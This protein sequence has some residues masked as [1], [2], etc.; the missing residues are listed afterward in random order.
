MGIVSRIAPAL[1]TATILAATPA[2]GSDLLDKHMAPFDRTD[3][4][5]CAVAL[6]HKGT[7]VEA[8]AYGLA[9]LDHDIPLQTNSVFR[10][11]SVSKQFTAMS[12]RLLIEDGTLAFDDDIRKHIPELPAYAHTVTVRHLMEHSSGLPYYDDIG[13]PY[14]VLPDY[15]KAVEGK[16]TAYYT[17]V[18]MSD[19]LFMERVL[20]VS[21]LHF[22][23]GTDTAY[24]NVGFF[25]LGKI[26]E[27]VSGKHLRDF[28]QER[29]FTP[30]GMTKTFFN[31]QT[32]APVKGRASPYFRMKN[33]RFI[34]W[35]TDLNWIGD[36]G[37]FTTV[38]DLAKWDGNFYSNQLGGGAA[39]IKSMVTSNMSRPDLEVGG[40]GAALGLFVEDTDF[41]KVVEHG[42][43]WVGFRTH[44][45]RHLPSGYGIYML[46]NTHEASGKLPAIPRA[47]LGDAIASAAAA[48]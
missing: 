6:T 31:T 45:E 27:R 42:G 1:L 21:K 34:E 14:E 26:V 4:P 8:K 39:L 46:C 48:K 43:E 36:G 3:A 35:Q 32:Y 12:A 16:E 9:N 23:P 41:G 40:K 5:G 13:F 15:V 44:S 10:I 19:S 25:L 38:E 33:G 2:V 17:P 47:I 7:I 28:A 24:N 20:K 29:I 18:F 11:A 37:I 30:L 22:K